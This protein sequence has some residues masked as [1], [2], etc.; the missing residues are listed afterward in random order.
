MSLRQK[1][2]KEKKELNKKKEEIKRLNSVEVSKGNNKEECYFIKKQG[3]EI[4]EKQKANNKDLEEL[5]FRLEQE[6]YYLQVNMLY[7]D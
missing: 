7:N 4:V 3:Q 5:L 6:L 1:I 2:H